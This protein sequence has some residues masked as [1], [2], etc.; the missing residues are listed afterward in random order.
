MSC[1]SNSGYL[2]L[3]SIHFNH[4]KQNLKKNV[5]LKTTFVPNL[6]RKTS[7]ISSY[8][9]GNVRPR[10]VELILTRASYGLS[11][12][13]YFKTERHLTTAANGS[14]RS[15]P[16]LAPIVT[17][18][19]RYLYAYTIYFRTQQFL[20]FA[21]IKPRCSQHNVLHTAFYVSHSAVKLAHSVFHI[22]LR[23]VACGLQSWTDVPPNR[24][25]RAIFMCIY[26]FSHSNIQKIFHSVLLFW[27]LVTFCSQLGCV[28]PTI[29]MLHMVLLFPSFE[30]NSC[31]SLFWDLSNFACSTK[32]SR[33]RSSLVRSLYHL[34]GTPRYTLLLRTGG[35]SVSWILANV[36]FS[37]K[38]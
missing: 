33:K 27:V 32:R 23:G 5:T 22:A 9:N 37:V 7:R 12:V 15:K 10:Q 34:A 26:H 21:C 3:S 36:E 19:Q 13:R 18:A 31:V 24:H 25:Y 4:W 1:S 16:I 20:S 35:I 8:T 17:H 30:R 29:L 6:Q 2:G 28:S 14:R 38:L 11:M